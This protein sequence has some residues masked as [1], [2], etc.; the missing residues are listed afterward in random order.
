VAAQAGIVGVVF[1]ANGLQGAGVGGME[2][3]VE[4]HTHLGGVAGGPPVTGPVARRADG[5]GLGERLAGPVANRIGMA[6]RR[7]AGGVA[8]AADLRVGGVDD[9]AADGRQLAG[10]GADARRVGQR[11]VD[12]ARPVA[13]LALHAVFQ[14]GVGRRVQSGDVAIGAGGSPVVFRRGPVFGGGERLPDAFRHIPLGGQDVIAAVPGVDQ[15]ALQVAPAAYSVGHV[16]GGEG[17]R[18]FLAGEEYRPHVFSGGK[19]GQD[20]RRVGAGVLQGA[21]VQRAHVV[22]AKAAMAGAALA[23]ADVGRF[24]A[25]LGSQRAAG[26]QQAQPGQHQAEDQKT[27]GS[28]G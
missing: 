19:I 13:G 26:E 5:I 10:A 9:R 23:A 21:G 11:H 2:P 28:H 6:V 3:L 25:A 22:A 12:A 7:R 15:V 8:L 24:I 17:A 16:S 4:L 1:A 18:R 27:H 20:R 14:P